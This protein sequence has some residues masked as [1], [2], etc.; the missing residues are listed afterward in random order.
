MNPRVLSHVTPEEGA[1][2]V[3]PHLAI[4]GE[5]ALSLAFTR[6][7]ILTLPTEEDLWPRDV[8]RPGPP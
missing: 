1:A 5:Q 7:M 8:F 4:K 2:L 3:R 6:D